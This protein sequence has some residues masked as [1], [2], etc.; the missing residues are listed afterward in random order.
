MEKQNG[1]CYYSNLPMKYDEKE[2]MLSLERLNSSL[3]YIKDNIVFCCAELNIRIQWSHT[4]IDELLNI[5]GNSIEDNT[6]NFKL[7]KTTRKK[8][9]SIEKTIINGDEYYK[10]NHCHEIKPIIDFHI[11][12]SNGCKICQHKRKTIYNAK[13]RGGMLQLFNTA[14]KSTEDRNKT[15]NNKRTNE[16]DI[17]FDYLVEIFNNQ[18]GLCVISGIP[19]K[20]GNCEEINWTC[21][22]ERI[23]PLIGYIKG[24]VCFICVEFQTPDYTSMYKEKQTGSSAWTKDKFKIFID[25]VRTHKNNDTFVSEKNVCIIQD[26]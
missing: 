21:S 10:C 6:M 13:P 17:D 19:M 8:A 23:D 11:I 7:V 24:N 3:G 25:S 22:L 9:E 4:K 18:E 15:Q 12:I 2:W 14:K 20:F 5:L 26:E 1:L 16:F